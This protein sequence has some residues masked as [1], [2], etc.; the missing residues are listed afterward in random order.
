MNYVFRLIA[1]APTSETE[2]TSFID[3]DGELLPSPVVGR[4]GRTFGWPKEYAAICLLGC[5]FASLALTQ[6]ASYIWNFASGFALNKKKAMGVEE[7]R[8]PKH[9]TAANKTT[10]FAVV[11][12]ALLLY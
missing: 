2:E 9:V 1:P 10:D 7:Q 6:A 3:A 5:V 12:V 8:Q 4:D 11:A